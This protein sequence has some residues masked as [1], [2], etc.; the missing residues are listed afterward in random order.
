MCTL[1]WFVAAHAVPHAASCS[2]C[3]PVPCP[4]RPPAGDPYKEEIEE[5][6]KLIMGEVNSRGSANHHT[7]AYQSRVGPVEWLQPYTDTTIRCKGG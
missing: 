7:L 2:S 4:I 3:D 6:V 1:M 5:C